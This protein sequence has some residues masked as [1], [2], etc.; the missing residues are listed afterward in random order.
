M[1]GT[2]SN[3]RMALYKTSKTTKK[4]SQTPDQRPFRRIGI[5]Y[6]PEELGYL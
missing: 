6:E 2:R 1:K 5:D 3:F 4:V